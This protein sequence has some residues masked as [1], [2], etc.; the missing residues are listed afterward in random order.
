[1]RIKT[2]PGIKAICFQHKI[3][4]EVYDWHLRIICLIKIYESVRRKYKYIVPPTL[5]TLNNIFINQKI[6]L[7]LNEVWIFL[8]DFTN[9]NKLRPGVESWIYFKMFPSWPFS[10]QNYIKLK[11]F[12]KTFKMFASWMYSDVQVPPHLFAISD[13]A[14]RNMLSSKR[15]ALI[16]Q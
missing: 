8:K 13:T 10:E 16:V 14:Y 4:K 15:T 6:I 5:N 2:N 11:Y 3:F 1:M 9:N 12:T 7:D